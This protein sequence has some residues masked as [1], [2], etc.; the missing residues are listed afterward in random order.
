MLQVVL[1]MSGTTQPRSGT[2]RSCTRNWSQRPRDARRVN[3]HVQG[4]LL[5]RHREPG[6]ATGGRPAAAPRHEPPAVVPVRDHGRQSGHRSRGR[7]VTGTL[8]TITCAPRMSAGC[9]ELGRDR[10]QRRGRRTA[11]R[12]HADR[13]SAASTACRVQLVHDHLDAAPPPC[14]VP[15]GNG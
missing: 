10:R 12:T 5:D 14:R 6:T 13:R 3:G 7:L 4:A 9:P 8:R 11:A 15:T 2:H 1:V